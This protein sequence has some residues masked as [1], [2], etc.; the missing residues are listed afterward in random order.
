M[1]VPYH[2]LILATPLSSRWLG[3]SWIPLIIA[4]I[5]IG[6]TIFAREQPEKW[7]S[8]VALTSPALPF[9][10][11]AYVMSLSMMLLSQS[12][13]LSLVNEVMTRSPKREDF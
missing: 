8:R 9:Y 10:L 7:R 11:V 3:L 4:Y 6:K 12:D 1:T 5:F 13:P 2:L